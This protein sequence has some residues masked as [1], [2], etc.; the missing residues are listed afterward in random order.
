MSH[1]AKIHSQLSKHLNSLKCINERKWGKKERGPCFLLKEVT[2]STSKIFK[3]AT[4][5]LGAEKLKESTPEFELNLSATRSS[6]R[7]SHQN[8]ALIASGQLHTESC[9]EIKW[10]VQISQA[11]LVIYKT[12]TH[13]AYRIMLIHWAF[14]LL[15]LS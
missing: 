3:K 10:H 14:S 7:W 5:Q 11:V 6:G 15:V 9:C 8:E 12:V 4:Q 2:L 1:C 13:L